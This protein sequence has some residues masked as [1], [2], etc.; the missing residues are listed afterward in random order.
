MSAGGRRGGAGGREQ[1][2]VQRA[3]VVNVASANALSFATAARMEGKEAVPGADSF[4]FHTLNQIDQLHIVAR[5]FLV[6]ALDLEK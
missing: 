6:I 1:K 5:L 4:T 2:L 3:S